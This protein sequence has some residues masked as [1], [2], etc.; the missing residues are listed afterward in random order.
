MEARWAEWL[1]V[2]ATALLLIPAGYELMRV[3]TLNR[4]VFVQFNLGVMA[5]LLWRIRRDADW[6]SRRRM[7]SVDHC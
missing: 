6:E 3:P 1:T 4:W 2:L 5:Y 7:R